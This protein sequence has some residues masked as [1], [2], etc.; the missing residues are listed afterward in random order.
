MKALVTVELQ[1]CSDFLFF[2]GCFNR[3]Q[4]K[5][6][7]LLGSGFV[8]N[9][10]VVIQISDNRKLQ[11]TLFGMNVRNI[12]NPFLIWSFSFEISV[13]KVGISVQIISVIAVF[14]ASD[15]R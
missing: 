4:N 6:Y 13:Q 7:V 1:L 9:N 2:L 10:T 11:Y 12:C 8:G 3:T 15:Y 5:I 14:L